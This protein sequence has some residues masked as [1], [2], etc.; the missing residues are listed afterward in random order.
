M[1]RVSLEEAKSYSGIYFSEKDLEVQL[2]IDAAE[3]FVAKFLNRDSLSDPELLL[4]ATDSPPPD[5]PAAEELRPAIKLLVLMKFD[6]SWQNR[7]IQ[8]VGTIL[9]ENPEWMRCAHLYRKNLGV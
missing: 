6:E 4:N 9:T 1:S 5:S 7:G 2:L 3:E 8:V